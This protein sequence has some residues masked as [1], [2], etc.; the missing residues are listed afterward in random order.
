[1]PVRSLNSSVLRWPDRRT[2][3]DA[4]ARWVE[5][6]AAASELC[7]AGYFGSYATGDWGVGSDLDVV[8]VV[9]RSDDPFESRAAG[10]DLTPL[11]VPVDILVYTKAEWEELLGRDDRFSR[12]LS[13]DAV[14]LLER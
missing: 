11:P 10:W 8:L 4:F 13:E 7:R 9:E 1:M 6:A 12:M 14:W 3:H 2:V 5:R